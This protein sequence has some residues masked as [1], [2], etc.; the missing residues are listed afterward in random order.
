MA[1]MACRLLLMVAL[2]LTTLMVWTGIAE[3][4]GGPRAT[5]VTVDDVRTEV[6]GETAPVIG[7]LVARQSGVVAARTS[8][9]VDEVLVDVG[10]RVKKGDIIAVMANERMLASR[11]AAA[12]VVRQP[13][14]FN[15]CFAERHAPRRFDRIDVN[16][17][18]LGQAV[19]VLDF[20]FGISDFGLGG[21]R[22]VLSNRKSRVLFNQRGFF[23]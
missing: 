3:A 23:Y 18:E 21:T 11:D 1:R 10:D 14:R 12:A 8:G 16:A 6:L 22:S 4:Q 19:G 7:R 9:A 5:A 20:G 13:T 2:G 17:D 15:D